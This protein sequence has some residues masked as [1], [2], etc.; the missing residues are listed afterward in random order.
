M[1]KGQPGSCLLFKEKK[2]V[3]LKKRFLEAYMCKQSG[4]SW[5]TRP[6]C[7]GQQPLNGRLGSFARISVF[8]MCCFP[9]NI[10][11]L[12]LLLWAFVCA[13]QNLLKYRCVRSGLLRPHV[14]HLCWTGLTSTRCCWQ[15][16]QSNDQLAKHD[17]I[18]SAAG[19]FKT[20][21]LS[22][23]ETFST[24]GP[25]RNSNLKRL[26]RLNQFVGDET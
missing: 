15:I 25:M 8:L 21:L 19:L 14:A 7:L 26:T 23:L 24:T 6:A 17:F 16:Y 11:P 22:H 13:E 20:R 10:W 12:G 4:W 1:L 9:F 2:L 18:G 5:D 3:I